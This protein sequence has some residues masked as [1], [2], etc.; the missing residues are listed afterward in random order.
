MQFPFVIF[1]LPRSRTAWLSQWLSYKGRRVGHDL[2]PHADTCQGYLDSLW[3]LSGTVETGIQDAHH[4]LRIAMP[5]AKF[6]VIRRPVEEVNHSL[7]QFGVEQT[8]EMHRRSMVLD[9]IEATRS[10]NYRDLKD[11]RVCADLW[12]YLLDIPF[13]FE[14]WRHMDAQNIQI[15]VPQQLQ[16]LAER[17]EPIT[18]L[19]EE[20]AS[21]SDPQ[22]Y[23]I[24]WEPFD[25]A[26]ADAEPLA[27]AHSR[28]VNNGERKGH[29]FKLDVELLRQMEQMGR[30]LVM[31]ARLNG[32][33]VGYLSWTL[34]E[35]AESAGVM[36]AD[37]GA[38]YVD[39]A[40][41]GFGK[42]MLDK[43]IVDLKRLGIHSIQ[44]HHQLHG[45]GAKL[46][47]LFTRLGA[48]ELQHR[49]GLWIGG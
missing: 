36:I 1:A 18:R 49:Y 10:I 27:L 11:V 26:W 19:K 40:T 22:F 29:P 41:P 20:M 12:E 23:R 31:T 44:F 42:K 25:S 2:A 16:F 39:T 43:S 3:P 6:V 32:K 45:R 21:L 28:E 47:A 9:Q 46:G 38:W 33:L 4:L 15:D 35:D 7:A 8:D 30:F 5:S 48:V 34:T 17:H 24:D 14:W 37:Q 13:D